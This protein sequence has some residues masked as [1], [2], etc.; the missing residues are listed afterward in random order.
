MPARRN[1]PSKLCTFQAC[2]FC[3]I[4]QKYLT[5]QSRGSALGGEASETPYVPIANQV[6]D[7]TATEDV[8]RGRQPC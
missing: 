8:L 7:V 1:L 5:F 4:T 6:A 3:E 2:V